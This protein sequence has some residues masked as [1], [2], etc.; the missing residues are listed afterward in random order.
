MDRVWPLRR[1]PALCPGLRSVLGLGL[2]FEP[3]FSSDYPAGRVF[4]LYPAP[5]FSFSSLGGGVAGGSV[6]RWEP[7]LPRNRASPRCTYQR[8]RLLRSSGDLAR[9]HIGTLKP[10]HPSLSRGELPLPS[11]T[12]AASRDPSTGE[13]L[14]GEVCPALLQLPGRGNLR[15]AGGVMGL[16]GAPLPGAHGC[17]AFH[18]SD[19]PI[20][21]GPH[22][23]ATM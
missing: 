3:E 18:R 7:P 15:G 20:C 10:T 6:R 5:G 8:G 4:P 19:P 22:D 23:H 21:G 16:K 11:P 12:V 9:Q 13:R 17:P 1:C 2:R 14:T